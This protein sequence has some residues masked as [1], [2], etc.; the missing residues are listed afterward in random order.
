MPIPERHTSPE[1]IALLDKLEKRRRKDAEVDMAIRLV[2]TFGFER[3]E[4]HWWH[5]HASSVSHVSLEWRGEYKG[6]SILLCVDRCNKYA[7]QVHDRI[8]WITWQPLPP[9]TWRDD[10]FRAIPDKSVEENRA[11]LLQSM[12]LFALNESDRLEK[13]SHEYMRMS[14]EWREQARRILEP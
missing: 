11:L 4:N 3:T 7:F 10:F 1:R 12:N 5:G 6:V 9:L 2:E 13:L 14:E 8:A